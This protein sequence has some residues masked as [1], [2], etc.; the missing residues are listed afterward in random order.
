MR[1]TKSARCILFLTLGCALPLVASPQQVAD[2]EFKPSIDTPTHSGANRPVVVL[3]EAHQ[4]FHTAGGRYKPFA[5]LL[6]A[7]GYI[8]VAGKQPFSAESLVGPR[9][10]VIA[11]AVGSGISNAN[12]NDPP[13]AFTDA[14]CDAVRD[15]V[16][17]GG[18]LLLIADHSPYGATA[19]RLSARFG[20]EMGTGYAW[21]TTTGTPPTTTI[22]HTRESSGLGRN[23]P[24]TQGINRVAA[25][26][27][28]S[29]SVP[30]GATALLQ[31]GQSSYESAGNEVQADMAAFQSGKPHKARS[32]A[33]RA[34]G[35][36][37][38]YG[39][40]RVVI[41]GE[42]AMFSAQVARFTEPNGRVNETKMGMNVAGNDN[43][44]F[45]V[46]IM[47]WLT[48]A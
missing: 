35:V 37:L 10:L 31:F 12:I 45:L 19:A 6:A 17:R 5:D 2:P 47:K 16:A 46:N 40:G 28:Q 39:K 33:G 44:Q 11:N 41:M 34:Q 32:I 14:E 23:H 43:R 25:F 24:I 30:P 7:D 36:A 8:V 48:R 38:D 9:V 4:N 27:G 42:A 1:L 26:T 29:L 13:S 15:W 21:Q 22:V 20:V 18:S 3:D